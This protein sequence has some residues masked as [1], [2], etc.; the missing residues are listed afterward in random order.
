MFKNIL[1]FL[2]V[3]WM[4]YCVA[5]TVGERNETRK[6]H[7]KEA[8]PKAVERMHSKAKRVLKNDKGYWEAEFDDGHIMVYIPDGEFTTGSDDGLPNEKPLHKVYL[9]GYWLGKHPVTVGQFREFTDQIGYVT[10]AEKGQGSWQF[11]EG[12]WVVRMNGNWKNPYFEQGEDHPVVS[13]SWNDAA[14]FCKWLSERTGVTFK[15]PTAAQWEKGARGTD[16]RVYPWGNEIPDGTRANYADINFWKKYGDSRKADK[17][18]DDGFTETSPVGSFPAGASPYGLLDMAGNV[19]EWCYD[20][21]DENYYSLSPSKN[22]FGPPDTGQ[23]DQER[24]NRGGGSWTDRSGHITPEGGHNLRSAARTGD[25]QNSSDDHMG[26]RLCI[27]SL[28]R[29]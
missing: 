10:D 20:V 4:F 27:D 17:T 29:K 19:W 18:V 8:I 6:T 11:W 24:V 25:E 1:K 3:G 22:P 26:F 28:P 13:I 23:P 5:C 14:A 21:Y 16:Q 7:S 12:R 9:D 15:L 2:W